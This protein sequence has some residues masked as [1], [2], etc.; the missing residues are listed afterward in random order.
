MPVSETDC[1]VAGSATLTV[2]DAVFGF[3]LPLVGLNDTFAVQ[4]LPA[5]N[6][7][8]QVVVRVNWFELVPPNAMLLIVR[9]PAP[10][11]VIVTC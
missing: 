1:E 9:S 7:A 8:P 11:L 3:G 4:L 10:V 5:A 2:N 6:V